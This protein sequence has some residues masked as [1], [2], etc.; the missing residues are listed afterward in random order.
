[1]LCMLP[2]VCCVCSCIFLKHTYDI[3]ICICHYA[4]HSRNSEACEFVH[5]V[6]YFTKPYGAD[7]YI[8][9]KP[10]KWNCPFNVEVVTFFTLSEKLAGEEITIWNQSH[11][12]PQLTN[13]LR[14]RTS[15]R[16][17]ERKTMSWRDREPAC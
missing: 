5:N 2:C 4:V 1:M 10:G 12:L 6:C 14:R 7:Q 15:P 3:Y 16:Q 8:R 9:I 13:R 17:S 11:C